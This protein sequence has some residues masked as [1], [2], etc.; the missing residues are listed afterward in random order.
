MQSFEQLLK[1]FQTSTLKGFGIAEQKLGIMAAGAILHY[2]KETEHPN[3]QHITGVQRMEREDFLWMDRFTIRNLELLGAG[4]DQG[5]YLLKVIDNTVSPMGAR[6]LRRWLIFPLKNT[7]AINERL[8]AVETLI[9]DQTLRTTLSAAIKACGDMERLV[10]K[11]PLK[12]I[13]PREVVQLARGLEQISIIKEA[14]AKSN[15]KKITDAAAL[16]DPIPSIVETI[17]QQI[18][19]NP[20]V[21]ANSKK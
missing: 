17:Y 5:N 4:V 3:L 10:S 18:A 13:N 12:K 21:A 20:P 11:V 2:L 15:N 19:E 6:L 8:D 7:A 9:K 16:L 14:A 1:Q